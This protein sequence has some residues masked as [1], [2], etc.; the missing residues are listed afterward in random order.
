MKNFNENSFIAELTSND[1]YD[2]I[3]NENDANTKY[4]IFHDHFLK[5]LEKYAPI[6]KISKKEQR[7][8]HKPWI[9]KGLSKSIKVKNLTYKKFMVTKDIFYYNRYK[10]MR[11]KINHLLRSEKKKYYNKYFES[12]KNNMKKILSKI[13]H[14]IHK[15]KTS[16]NAMCLNVDGTI[17]S[18]P[19]E[20]GNKFNTFYT[21]VPQKLVDQ[22]KQPKNKYIDYLKNP[23]NNS[24]YL[25]PTTPNEIEQLIQKL[26][27]SKSSDIFDISIKIVKLSSAYISP[28][29]SNIFNKSFLD[30]IFPQKLKYAFVLPLHKCGSKLLL[31]N[32]RPISILPILSKILEQL[33][34]FR[35]V[36]YLEEQ[37]IIYEHQ[38]GFQRNKSTSLAILDVHAKIIEAIENKQ[39]ACSVFLDFAK[40]FDTVNHDILLGKLNHYGI[41]GITNKWFESYLKN[42]YQKVKIGSTLSDEKLIT[43]GVPRGSV[44][45][46]ILFLIYIND[47]KESS[48][49][50]QFYL[51][52][53]D[54]STLFCHEDPTT[55]ERVYN[56][57]LNKISDWLAA[58][59]LSLNVSKSNVVLFNSS[60]KKTKIKI[61]LK[62]K[63]EI[64][65]EKEFTKYLRV[66][67][68]KQ[69]IMVSTH[70]SC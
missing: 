16:T 48:D 17:I 8:K 35:L 69:V 61:E 19:F 68:E 1:I 6:K 56:T 45:G 2:S 60:R 14:I 53:D 55:I 24:C 13:N 23:T 67:I 34:Q 11:D 27:C 28:I 57:E 4:E 49:V 38:F 47:I 62:I 3:N 20:V 51:F 33:M 32:Y 54:T 43:C 65:L 15:R 64:I 63:K 59:R 9:T 41:R 18:D 5:T 46:P 25:N 29:L 42:R 21:T 40:T 31:T 12:N 26:D 7:N 39:L 50:L 70:S 30:G 44:L 52:A 22:M 36:K 58:N 66:L 37:N 10:V